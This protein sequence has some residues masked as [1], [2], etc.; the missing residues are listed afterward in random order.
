[1][2]LCGRCGVRLPS[3]RPSVHVNILRKSLLL[4][5]KWLDRH[6]TC[7]R[8][9]PDRP[10]SMICS[11]SRSTSKVMWYRHFC[12]FTKIA[13]SRRQMAGSPPNLHTMVRRR[14]RIQGVLKVKVEVK[15]HVI[16]TLLWFHENC[17][18]S[19]NGQNATKLAH[20]GS[21]PGLHPGCAQGQGRGQGSRD[22]G[23]CVMSRN[24]CYTVP[25]DV[26][27]LHALTLWST[28]TLS[29]YYKCQAARCNVYIMEWATPSFSMCHIAVNMVYKL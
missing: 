26:L 29:V 4:A 17:F 7:T 24:V 23:T 9:S 14:A 18:F 10:A 21:Q 6:Q 1:M 25:S 11:R 2:Q 27:S 19:Q 12:D 13:S 16:G 3:V 28:I 5:G 22:T 15:G 20:D 8:W